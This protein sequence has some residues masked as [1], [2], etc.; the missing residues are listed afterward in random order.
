[1]F[2]I[3]DP[4]ALCLQLF[5]PFHQP[6]YARLYGLLGFWKWNWVCLVLVLLIAGMPILPAAES[7]DLCYCGFGGAEANLIIE[8]FFGRVV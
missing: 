2:S 6:T 3:M 8:L 4:F 5:F 1:M 7:L